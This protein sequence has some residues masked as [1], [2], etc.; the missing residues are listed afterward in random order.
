[1]NVGFYK[2]HGTGNDFII[3]DG[4]ER[5]IELSKDEIAHLCHRRFG[6][7]A[8]GL[9]IIRSSETADF[10]M[11]Y[12]NSDGL[13][14]SLCGNGSRC[15]V[16][17]AKRLGKI[18]N[19]CT[20]KAIDGIHKAGF[21]DREWVRIEMKSGHITIRER[22][23]ILNTGSPHYV[24]YIDDL[25]KIDV[26][27]EGRRIRNS[28]NFLQDGINVNFV[29][30]EGENLIKVATYERGV[31]DETYSCG[32]GVTA[33]A[34][35]QALRSRGEDGRHEIEVKTKGGQLRVDVTLNNGRPERVELIGPA[36]FVFQGKV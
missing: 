14:S 10:F 8:D 7:G 12:F 25:S 23:Y 6:I 22:D 5:E 30:V 16:A 21:D 11:D 15:A 4:F 29:E 2:Y 26:F 35:V 32:T 3:V 1:M 24:K 31:E 34:I 28:D 36:E 17:L 19:Q 13:R 20:F 18:G 27:A 9:I 33:C